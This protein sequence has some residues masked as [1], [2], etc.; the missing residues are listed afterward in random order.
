MKTINAC[1]KRKCCVAR[2]TLKSPGSGRIMVNNCFLSV[3]NPKIYRDRISEPVVLAGVDV[4]KIDI[5][6]NTV[7]G[8]IAS[9]ADASRLAI[10]KALVQHDK[11]LQKKFLEYDRT[12]LIADVRFKE[13]RKPN[14]HGKARSKVQ[15]SYR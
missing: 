3:I 5:F 2:A 1:G 4:D 9:I 11:K 7:G 13:V 15:K 14:C 8:G 12:L 10:A 6:V